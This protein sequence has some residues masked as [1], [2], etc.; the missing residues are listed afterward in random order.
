MPFNS[1][2]NNLLWLIVIISACV[3][4]LIAGTGALLPTF[5]IRLLGEGGTIIG[6]SVAA[7][8][9]LSAAYLL[10]YNLKRSE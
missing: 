5:I 6:I 7:G 9:M 1:K 10:F 8:T 4:G 2:L 3:L